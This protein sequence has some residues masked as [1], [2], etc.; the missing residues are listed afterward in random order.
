VV[1]TVYG[2]VYRLWPAVKTSPLAKVQCWAAIIAVLGQVA[3]AYLFA[4]SGDQATM[5]VAFSSMLA[6]LAGG[7]MAWMFWTRTADAKSHTPRPQ[8]AYSP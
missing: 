5:I 6:I 3:G 1:L 8:A 7:L 4:T 2:M